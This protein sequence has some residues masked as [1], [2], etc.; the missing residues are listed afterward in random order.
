[1][2]H[3]QCT[4]IFFE[5]D[6]ERARSMILSKHVIHYVPHYNMK[7]LSSRMH[8]MSTTWGWSVSICGLEYLNRHLYAKYLLKNRVG[9]WVI[10]AVVYKRLWTYRVS[11]FLE[12]IVGP[13]YMYRGTW[14]LIRNWNG[15][16]FASTRVY[17]CCFGVVRFAFIHCGFF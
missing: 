14:D 16:P 1:M 3:V 8:H 12:N 11:L 4:Y 13:G 9:F 2:E 7:I 6:L 15:L 10:L 17:P 5:R